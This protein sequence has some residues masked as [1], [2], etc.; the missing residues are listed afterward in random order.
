[1]KRREVLAAGAAAVVAPALPL[2][3][4]TQ[5]IGAGQRSRVQRFLGMLDGRQ[6]S[7]A[8]F[9]YDSRQ[10]RAWNYMLGSRRAPGL[11]LEQMTPEQKEAA[12]DVL[13][14]GLSPLGFEKAL[15]IML[16]QDIL[17]DEWGKGAA[18]RNRER[19][20][21]MVFGEP[22]LTQPWGW[23]WEGHHL[24]LSFTLRGEVVVGWTPSAFASEPNI[25]TSGPHSGLMVLQEEEVL[26]RALYTDL[27][28][29]NRARALVNP[30]SPA[31]IL[32]VAG[33]EQ[34]Y[35]G[36]DRGAFVGDMTTTQADLVA[37]L[38]EVYAVEWLP[39][40][41]ADIQAARLA[42]NTPETMRFVWAGAD[43]EGDSIYYRFHNE[44]VIVEFS[45]VRNQPLHLHTVFHDFG[46]GLG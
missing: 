1:M 10:R 7:Q 32:T 20:S 24:T 38:M 25:V 8:T 29:Q 45:N 27:S 6:R 18:D 15:N 44:P 12:L 35:A 16:Q 30:R 39:A 9:A 22:S 42:A 34:R 31:N 3:A 37:R 36:D 13:A 23:R 17:R 5:A 41:L 11:A 33:R 21:L 43:L 19:F 40:P 46:R 14:S 4:Q 28:G 26:G 2:W